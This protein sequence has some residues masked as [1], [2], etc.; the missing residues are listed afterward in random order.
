MDY[1]AIRDKIVEHMYGRNPETFWY[2]STE[3]A[4]QMKVVYSRFDNIQ[5][6]L[7]WL[8]YMVG[9]QDEGMDSGGIVQ[10]IGGGF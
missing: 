2:L 6:L 7:E 8:D 5:A 10:S 3:N 9:M 4:R 1:R